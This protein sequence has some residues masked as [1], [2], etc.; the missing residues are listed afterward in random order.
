M[1]ERFVD[2]SRRQMTMFDAI[3]SYEG[4]MLKPENNEGRPAG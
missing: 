4:D 1:A 3:I 2:G